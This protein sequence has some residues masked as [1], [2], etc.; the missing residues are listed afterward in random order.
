M[1]RVHRIV[2]ADTV[3]HMAD[4]RS[5]IDIA[6][7]IGLDIF[8][9][10]HDMRRPATNDFIHSRSHQASYVMIASDVDVDRTLHCNT[11]AQYYNLSF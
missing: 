7:S 5:R 4:L 11:L 6:A 8:L 1:L 9:N 2:V 10:Y 3:C